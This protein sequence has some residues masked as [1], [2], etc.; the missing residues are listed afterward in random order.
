MSVSNTASI[1]T[2]AG[3]FIGLDTIK[4]KTDV[5]NRRTKIFCTIGPACWETEQLETLMDSGMN[6]ARFNFSHGDHK[7]HGATLERLRTAAKNKQRNIAVLLDTK[8]PEIRTGFFADGAKKIDLGKGDSITLTS[9]YSFKGDKTKLACSYEKLATSVKKGQSILV[10]DGSLVLTV[11]SCDVAQGEV[12]C[13]IENTCSLGERKNMNL[14]GVVV[15]LPTFTE[16]DVDDIVNFGIKNKVD[17]IAA[18]FVRKGDDV[19]NLRQLLSD[20]GGQS[21]K[22]ISKIENQ[23][24]LENYDEILRYTDGI[25]VARGDLGME[26]PPSKVFLAQ[27]M[28]IRKANIAG[29]PVVTATQMLES[30][31]VNPR[32]TRAECSDVA[33]A[34]LDG[35]DAVML[36]GETANGPYFEQAVKVMA[37]TCV[38]AENSRNYNALFQSV[39]NSVIKDHGHLAHSESLASSAVKTAIDVKAQLIVVLSETGTTARYVAKFRPGLMVIC[40]TPNAGIARQASGFFQ[41]VHAFLVDSLEHT[42]TL[43]TDVSIEAIKAGVAKEGDL[44][45][46]IAGTTYGQGATDQIRVESISTHYWDEPADHMSSSQ[47]V[48]RNYSDGH[49]KA[50]FQIPKFA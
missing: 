43:S 34:V 17:F 2:L 5:T 31:I 15:D 14:P 21:I 46:I 18:S 8:G 3:A 27:K 29:K 6:V 9:D 48:G 19:K 26:I 1:P 12:L 22:I 38:E 11:L 25:M 40:L 13:R 35:T 41:G 39:R 50:G 32:P 16:K 36:S 10:A 23:E 33:N 7:G 49:L 20:N 24:G 37:R 4:K 44:M 47:A 42:E 30:M 45:V 28:M